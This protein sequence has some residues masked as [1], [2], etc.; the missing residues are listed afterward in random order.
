MRLLTERWRTGCS[1]CIQVLELR[2]VRFCGYFSG[3][4]ERACTDCIAACPSGALAN[5][6]PTPGGQHSAAVSRQTHR[7]RDG[8]LRFDYRGCRQSISVMEAVYGEWSCGR[9]LAV[10]AESRGASVQAAQAFGQAVLA[11]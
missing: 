11:V 10:C 9:C 8:R 6:T 4:R 2:P 1:A 3:V 7:F 5:S